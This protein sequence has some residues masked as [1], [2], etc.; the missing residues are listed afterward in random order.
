MCRNAQFFTPETWL[1]N[2]LKNRQRHLNLAQSKVKKMEK[3]ISNQLKAK[4]SLID[5]SSFSFLFLSFV[6]IPKYF[7]ESPR[8]HL[9]RKF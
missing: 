1:L 9:L 7:Y 6:N 5:A 8:N 4:I 3:S 2:D